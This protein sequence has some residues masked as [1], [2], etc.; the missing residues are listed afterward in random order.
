MIHHIIMIKLKPFSG[1]DEKLEKAIEIKNALE[2]LPSKIN[3]IQFY[4]VGIN[5]IESERASD[6]VL[7]SKF[8]NT[9][10]LN[11]YV[12]NSYHQAVVSIIKEYASNIS[13]VDHE[14]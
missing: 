13:S 10:E 6:L 1:K 5:I 14:K 2:T 9:N 3:E 4:E 7:I 12:S 8:K 11:S